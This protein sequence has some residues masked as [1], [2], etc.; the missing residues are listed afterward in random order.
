MRDAVDSD[1]V[2]AL[3]RSGRATPTSP[4]E[5]GGGVAAAGVGTA[6]EEAMTRAEG[7]R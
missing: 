2:E 7:S 1:C 6:E 3:K 4:G 5:E